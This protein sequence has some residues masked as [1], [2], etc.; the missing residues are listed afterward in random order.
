MAVSVKNL[1]IPPDILLID[2]IHRIACPLPQQ[3]IVKGDSASISIAAA[4]IIAKVI[5]DR[6]MEK[7]H[8]QYPVFAF[9][10]HKGYPTKYHKEAIRTHG[11]CPIHR[12]TFRGVREYIT[13]N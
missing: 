7:Y 6:L 1:G 9:D 4:S 12:T 2:G 10:K 11:S 5:R 13:A 3:T 8:Q